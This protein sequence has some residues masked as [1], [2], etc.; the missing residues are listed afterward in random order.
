MG[1]EISIALPGGS[2]GALTL[3]RGGADVA[4]LRV[5]VGRPESALAPPAVSTA[6]HS[7]LVSRARAGDREA[8]EGLVSRY[9]DRVYTIIHGFVRDPDEA[10]DLVQD[11]FIKAY[12]ALG[13]FKGNAGFY[14]WLYRIAI[15][16]CKD[17]ARKKT[18]RPCVSLE[19]E[20][21][22][23]VGF[24]PTATDPA[25]DPAGMA[26]T[27]ELRDMVRDAIARLPEKLRMA[28]ILHD[29]QGL[30]QQDVANILQCPV[31]TAKSHVFRGRARLRQLL[32]RYVEGGD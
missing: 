17:H 14:T 8:F 20:Q 5:D 15:N 28:I 30:P 9:Q 7:P 26:E 19:D 32:G 11:T 16:N 23:E 21:F 12:Q 24:E 31:G 3:R 10:L 6:D 18:A 25:C 22:Q 27:R 4:R 2:S 1:Q 29:I 13:G